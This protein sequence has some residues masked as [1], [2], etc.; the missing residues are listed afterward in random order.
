MAD[1]IKIVAESLIQTTQD[2]WPN[3]AIISANK[4]MVKLIQ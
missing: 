3:V 1:R 4:F 2:T